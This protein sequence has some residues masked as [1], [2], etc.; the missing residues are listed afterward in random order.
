MRTG[1]Y[2]ERSK[3]FNQS[4][5]ITVTLYNS[6]KTPEA[7]KINQRDFDLCS[8]VFKTLFNSM[9]IYTNT[10][11]EIQKYDSF[12]CKFRTYARA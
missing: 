6:E 11:Q 7:S 10:K 1:C 2:D 5:K 8:Q 9:E 3:V 4:V 12:D